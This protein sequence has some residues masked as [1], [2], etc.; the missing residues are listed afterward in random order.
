MN[1]YHNPGTDIG[2][3]RLPAIFMDHCNDCQRATSAVTPIALI[4]DKAVAQVSVLQR[5]S[6][7]IEGAIDIADTNREWKPAS[8]VL[9]F[10]S[11]AGKD[12]YLSAYNSSPKRSRWFCSR[13][14]T[15]FAYS[16]GRGVVPPEWGWPPMVD[17]WLGTVDREDLEKDYMHPER[18][19]YCEKGVPWALS[20]ARHGAGGIPEH[21]L[22][23]IDKLIGDEAK[24]S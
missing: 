18:M 2:D 13:C 24:D 11:L 22:T 23:R 15:P 4:C 10:D 17:F 9:D 21:P 1:P 5:R 16:V 12:W 14:G 6:E 8:E 3:L 20:L 19:V 7:P